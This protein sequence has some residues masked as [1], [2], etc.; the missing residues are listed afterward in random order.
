MIERAAADV[1]AVADDHARADPALD[2]RVPERAGVEVHEALVHDGRAVGEVG[3]E[4]DAV[5]V[6]HAHAARRRRSRSCAGTCRG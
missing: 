3:A 2:H 5:G 4:A 6:G 1:R